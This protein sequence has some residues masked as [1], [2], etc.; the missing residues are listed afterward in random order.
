M[1]NSNLE[2]SILKVLCNNR[3]HAVD[4]V[5]ECDAKL[6]SPDVW[7]FAN[8]L[9][10]YIKTY[11]DVPTLRIL[12][13]RL[14]KGNNAEHVKY[15]A[16]LWNKVDQVQYDDREYKYDLE[17]LKNRYAETEFGKLKDYLAKGDKIDVQRAVLE[18]QKII[19]SIKGLKEPKSYDRRTLRGSVEEFRDE[20]NAKLK[21]PNF[22]KGIPTGYSFLDSATDGLRAGEMLLIGGESGHGK[23]MFLMNMALQMWM[24][25]NTVDMTENFT[26][27]YNVLYFSLEMP[28]KPCRNRI[29]S[30]LAGIPS[31]IIRNPVTKDKKVKLN[32]EQR[33]KL[34]SALQFIEKYPYEF[35]II[36]VPRGASAERIEALLEEAK[37]EFN[38][39]IIVVDYL[40]IMDDPD[41][42]E[43]DDWLKLG[44]ISGKLHEIAR[45]H[46]VIMLSA[47]QLNR[48]KPNKEVEE[49]I[50]MHRI[51]RSA[52]IMHHANIAIQIEARPNEKQYPDLLYHL[53]KNRD[54]ELGKGK[55]IKNFACGTLLDD[56]L[57]TEEEDVGYEFTDFDDLSEKIEFFD[58]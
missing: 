11:K 16:D 50:G 55:L 30:R 42:K 58:I 48:M 31:K 51:G 24:Q 27:G 36:D 46:N 41:G 14:S 18:T 34:K 20:F 37:L 15:V 17:K 38:P 52:L 1:S 29:L 8:L 2:L 7:N 21:D 26:K 54:G 32:Q 9:L 53:I 56:R 57:D 47:V 49:K 25:N 12:T 5:S 19:Q 23:S 35:E 22:D 44:I 6:F 43:L 39:D 33:E 4:F 45:V 28:R 13:E 40:G 3:K 10:G